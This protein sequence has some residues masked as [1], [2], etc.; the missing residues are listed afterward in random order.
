MNRSELTAA[1]AEITG[2]PK[3]KADEVVGAVFETLVE[4]L[5]GGDGVR[6]AGFGTFEV[7]QRNARKGRNPK[8]GEEIATPAARNPVFRAGKGLKDAVNG[9]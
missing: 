4:S 3:S 9:G 2:L 8:T 7:M 6:L 1:V 5:K